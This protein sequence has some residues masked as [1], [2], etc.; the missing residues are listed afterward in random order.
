VGQLLQRETFNIKIGRY[1]KSRDSSVGIPLGYGLDDRGSTV[2]FPA[3]SGNFSFHYRVKNGSGDHLASYLMGTRGS[4]PGEKRPER[5]ADHSPP[6]SAE[7]K[8]AWSYTSTPPI[9]LHGVV[10]R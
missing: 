5:E 10:L 1:F 2:R 4:L 6:S 7:V 9:H 3:G 8:N